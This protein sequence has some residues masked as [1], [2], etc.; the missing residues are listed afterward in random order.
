MSYG[1]RCTLSFR[2]AKLTKFVDITE[3]SVM[4]GSSS[5]VGEERTSCFGVAVVAA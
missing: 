3:L 2:R 1:S 4:G 5:V